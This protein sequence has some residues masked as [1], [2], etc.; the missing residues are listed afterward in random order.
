MCPFGLFAQTVIKG[1]VTDDT[2]EELPGVNVVV[3]GTSNGTV[4]DIFGDYSLEVSDPSATL[5]FSFV[6]FVSQ[7]IVIG[8][9]SV[10]D[11]QLVTDVVS[12]QEVVVV[13]YGTT[14]EKELTASVST[15]KSEDITK[16]NPSRIENVLQGQISGVQIT[17]GSGSPG[18]GQNIRIRGINSNG[19]NRPLIILDGVRYG[20][21]LSTIDPNNIESI[22]VLKDASAAIYGVLGANGV[23]I[24]TTKSGKSTFKPELSF[25]GFYGI[26]ETER[27]INLLNA[28]EYA[29]LT[30]EAFAAGGQSPIFTDI[31]SL[32]EGTDW[33]DEVFETAPIQNYS[34]NYRGSTESTDYSAGV[35]YFSQEGIV[36]GSK[37]E[38]DRVNVNLN[39][40]HQ[41][42][43]KLKMRT[44]MNYISINRKTLTENVLGSV[45]FNAIN[46][47]PTE[48]I[49]D[50]DGNFTT[51]DNLG[52]EII[53]PLAQIAN[54]F[55]DTQT[56]RLTG[57][58]GLTYEIIE[59]LEVESSLN[60]NYADVFTRGFQP[61][62]SFG[63]S[64]VF[65]SEVSRV[66]QSQQN[67]ISYNIDNIVRYSRTFDEVHDVSFTLGNSIYKTR[68]QSLFVSGRDI[69]NNTFDF[70]DVRLAN[71]F[72]EIRPGSS[73]F[74]VRQFS[75][76]G[77]VEYNYE[78]KYLFSGLIRSDETSI[79]APGNQQ[80]T[81]F[82]LSGGWVF[83]DE[84]FFPSL[85][86]FDF[87]KLRVSYGELGNDRVDAFGYISQLDGEAETVF[88]GDDL[89]FGRAIG[90]LPNPE[91]Q[92]ETTKQF[93][94]GLDLDFFEGKIGIVADYYVKTTEDLLIPSAPASG[95]TG[96][97]A[98]GGRGPSINAGEVRNKGFEF[99]I[100][101]NDEV[102]K[103]LRVSANFNYARNDNETLQV[104]DEDL[105]LAF[106]SFGVGGD[107]DISR[108]QKGIPI[109]GYWG[110]TTNGIFQ[111]AEEIAS[112]AQA[113]SAQP[114]DI[115]F[116]DLNDDGIIDDE[117]RSFIGS[118]IPENIFGFTLGLNYKN[119]DFSTLWEA[120]TGHSFVRNYERTLPRVNRRDD[121]IERW[122]GPGTSNSFPRLTTGA[123]NNNLFS[124][125]FV[126]DGDYLRIRNIQLGYTLPTNVIE[127][128]GASKIRIYTSVNNVFTF[129]DYEGF[130]PSANNGGPING[131]NDQGFYP[132]A[133]TY[134]FGFNLTF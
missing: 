107:D 110:Y 101:Y 24:V 40:G 13:G 25:S 22:T 71:D 8:S 67:F 3:K 100:S 43:E 37:S 128:I 12:L 75:Y 16:L 123:S 4:T 57:L 38:F 52:I 94:V 27:T 30:N 65:N 96:I 50:A 51:A 60:F 45:L 120:Q 9:Q 2:G 130:D 93:D 31:A 58:V 133:R 44:N 34:L 69:P 78:S 86:F 88:D 112:S 29:L 32:G 53:N 41:L 59:G 105:F 89:V 108:F 79:F 77:R 7:E 66:D 63:D 54:T 1:K 81:F 74:D 118:P 55:N 119:F 47:A 33:Q 134:I 109:G 70:A 82:S 117:D 68:G 132:Q 95:L 126:E 115:R 83:S 97:A 35:S 122:T 62:I 61:E 6:G 23:V 46:I 20:D 90:R 5:V 85:D 111:S 36:G 92:W 42:F 125:F 98:P 91:L 104:N 102:L 17:S 39:V 28:T 48:A 15:I 14:T 56:Q 73:S 114:G 72:D 64:K 124:D 76:F 121:A 11:V 18:G 106:G 84:S 116:V 99:S 113:G 103:D 49:F 10:V 21:D 129:T 26:Q 19:D 80:G 131:T 127:K 87:G